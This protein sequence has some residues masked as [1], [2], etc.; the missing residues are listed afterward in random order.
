MFHLPI[1]KLLDQFYNAGLL[2]PRWVVETIYWVLVIGLAAASRIVVERPLEK[3]KR[4][5]PL[6]LTG[7][8]ARVVDGLAPRAGLN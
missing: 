6:R 1:Q 2:R 4:R 3:L 8:E 5:F 7:A